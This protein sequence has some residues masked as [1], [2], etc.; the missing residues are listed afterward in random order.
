M[1]SKS[2]EDLA[3]RVNDLTEKFDLSLRISCTNDFHQERSIY[4]QIAVRCCF[5]GIQYILGTFIEVTT[6]LFSY[7]RDM[8][9]TKLIF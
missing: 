2:T 8:E 6:D 4:T 9:Q 3:F 5:I 7:F 1:E